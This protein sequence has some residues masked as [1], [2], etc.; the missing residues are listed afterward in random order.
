[1][2]TIT[3]K[4]G[5]FGANVPAT[6][7]SADLYLPD[8]A[9]PG[10]VTIV[11]LTAVAE[12]ESLKGDNTARF[13]SAA[14]LSVRG[15]MTVGPV[16][17][18]AG[19]LA[20]SHVKEV[21]FRVRLKDGRAFTAV[22]D[23]RTYAD[24]HAAQIAAR[25]ESPYG[26]GQADDMIAKYLLAQAVEPEALP[27]NAEPPRTPSPVAPTEPAVARPVFGRRGR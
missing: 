27:L 12:I 11:P 9:R 26:S 13:K 10:A 1:V 3:L 24:L 22:A 7:G 14:K 16:G 23:A 2:P 20:A 17:L 4:D 18:A 5:D 19:L 15:F 21:V 25:A 8:R 6:V